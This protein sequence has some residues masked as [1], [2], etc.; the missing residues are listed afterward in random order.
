MIADVGDMLKVSGKQDRD[1]VGAAQARQ[2]ADDD[3]E[4]DAD[5]HHHDV[6]RLQRHREAVKQICRVLPS[7]LPRTNPFKTTCRTVTD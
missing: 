6:E 5:H 2:H 1:A 7:S 4:H 3:A